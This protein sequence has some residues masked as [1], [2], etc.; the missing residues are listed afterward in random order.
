[1]YGMQGPRERQRVAAYGL[2]RRAGDVL[3]TRASSD[4]GSPGTWW[5]PG[6]GVEFGES[7]RACLAREF[8]E[9]TGLE[10]RVRGLV[11]VVS[12]VTE[13]AVGDMV[14]T[15]VRLHSIRIIYDV[16]VSSGPATPE[17]V[18]STD[19]VQWVAQERLGDV[20]LIP[21]LRD[22]TSTHLTHR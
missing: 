5:L 19:A 16:A 7:P 13:V 1:M 4:S 10:V 14:T 18:G 3:L 22:L 21:W 2:V 12:D 17:A 6:G 9:E 15:P 8:M 20:P 11:D